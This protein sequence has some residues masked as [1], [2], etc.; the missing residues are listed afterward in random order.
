MNMKALIIYDDFNL[1]VKAKAMIQRAGHHADANMQWEIKPWRVDTLKFPT[2]ARE[3]M[4]E[5]AD[6]HLIVFA[7]NCVR[8]WS[9]WLRDWLDQ[10][11]ENR[12]IKAAALAVIGAVD[13]NV[14][15]A[16][17][18]ADLSQ[19]ARHHGLN[20]IVGDRSPIGVHF[21]FQAEPGTLDETKQIA[22]LAMPHPQEL[23]KIESRPH[24]GLNE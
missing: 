22:S 5:A 14:F 8:S 20:F 18:T 21:S 7:G 6:A 24:W 16:L 1:A 19:Y 12:Q 2:T 4:A 3:A 15:S 13:A 23:A 17:E 10:W 9:S 11:A